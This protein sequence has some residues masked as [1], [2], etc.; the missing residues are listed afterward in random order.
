M[1]A[2]FVRLFFSFTYDECC[3]Y[4]AQPPRAGSRDTGCPALAAATLAVVRPIPDLR[5]RHAHAQKQCHASTRAWEPDR[6]SNTTLAQHQDAKTPTEQPRRAASTL[7]APAHCACTLQAKP[8][9]TEAQVPS[10][11]SS[12]RVKEL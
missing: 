1:N 11:V 12:T 5:P 9:V 2:L 4:P 7:T 6:P 10:S 3:M 8:P